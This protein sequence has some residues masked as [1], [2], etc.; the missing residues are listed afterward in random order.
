MPANIDFAQI[1]ELL[2]RAVLLGTLLPGAKQPIQLPDLHFILRQPIIILLDKHL[3]KPISLVG[4]PKPLRVMSPG[5][6]RQYT[7][8]EGDTA[9][10]EFGPI[11]LEGDYVRVTLAA[12][13]TTR[14]PARRPLGLSSVHVRFRRANMEWRLLGEPAYS[15]E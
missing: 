1:Q 9:Y 12:R 5:E 14:D 6:L 10:L 7:E 11:E 4:T 15:A 3:S 13:I 2:L 8:R